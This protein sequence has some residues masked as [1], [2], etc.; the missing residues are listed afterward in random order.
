MIGYDDKRKTY[1]VQYKFKDENGKWHTTRKRGFKLRRLA[2]EYESQINLDKTDTVTTR[3]TFRDIVQLWEDNLQ[4][5]KQSRVKHK[6][7]FEKRFNDF[8]DVDIS[9]ITKIQLIEWRNWLSN[10]EYSTKTKNMTMSYVR[11]VY[12]FA[13]EIYGVPNI[14]VILKGFKKTDDEI[15]SSEMQIWTVV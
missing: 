3:K 1:Y 8:L 2:V 14:A 5:S 13:N 4:S 12:K 15:M 6:E 9:R 10:A 7:H 11:S